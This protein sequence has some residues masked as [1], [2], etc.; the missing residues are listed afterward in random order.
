VKALT[1]WQPWA[2]LVA[3]G[4]KSVE[5]RVWTTKYRGP[6]AIH[7][8]KALPPDWL[9]AS[10]HSRQF[11]FELSEVLHESDLRKAVRLLPRGAV[12]AVARLVDVV[13]AS[14]IRDEICARERI[15]GN[16]EDGRYGWFLELE[17]I[18]EYPIFAKGSRL[19]W[20]WNDALLGSPQRVAK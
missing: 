18:F 13:P 6:L 8:A 14:E 9:G 3:L 11:Q 20:N 12:L 2:S 10:R 1:L 19:L 17:D 7:A 16:Y 4:H 5:T 15:F